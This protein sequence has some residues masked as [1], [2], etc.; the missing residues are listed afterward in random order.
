MQSY[1]NSGFKFLI[2][3]NFVK[4]WRKIGFIK[5][6][7]N[8]RFISSIFLHS[9]L[10]IW[11]IG[12]GFVF[13]SLLYSLELQLLLFFQFQHLKNHFS[14]FFEYDVKCLCFIAEQQDKIGNH[15]LELLRDEYMIN[16]TI[17]TIPR[18]GPFRKGERK[19]DHW[20]D[21]EWIN[22]D[23]VPPYYVHEFE[24]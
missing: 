21:L 4:I 24:D 9:F 23:P 20:L 15:I 1:E 12:I 22:P 3:R 18:K 17:V 8:P 7:Y 19:E 6:K 14:P 11:L 2:I 10:I 16:A 5:K 13:R